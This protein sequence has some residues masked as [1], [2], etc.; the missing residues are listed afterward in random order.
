MSNDL[1]RK[2]PAV[3][4]ESVQNTEKKVKHQ[5][6][7]EEEPSEFAGVRRCIREAVQNGL[8]GLPVVL[9]PMIAEYAYEYTEPSYYPVDSVGRQ[10]AGMNVLCEE[11]LRYALKLKKIQIQPHRVVINFDSAVLRFDE[12]YICRMNWELRVRRKAHGNISRITTFRSQDELDAHFPVQEQ[13]DGTAT[14]RTWSTMHRTWGLD[15]VLAYYFVLYLLRKMQTIP[16]ETV[17]R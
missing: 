3:D 8:E 15:S 4:T 10:L 16:P 17:L 7:K 11:G 9:V 5:K 2:R 12:I 13:T 14:P 6:D 1:S